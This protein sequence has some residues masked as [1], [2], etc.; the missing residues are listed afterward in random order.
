M[1]LMGWSGRR[2]AHGEVGL[3][4]EAVEFRGADRLWHGG[5][6][7]S[8]IRTGEEVIISSESDGT[9]SPFGGVVV[10]FQAAI[11]RVARQRFPASQRIL[12][13]TVVSDSATAWSSSLPATVERFQQGPRAGLP[14]LRRSSGDGRGSPFRSRTEPRS[15]PALP[16]PP[17]TCGQPGDRRISFARAPSKRPR[18]SPRRINL[19]DPRVP[20]GLQ[21][22]REVAQ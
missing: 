11:F 8:V 2:D 10:D 5:A 14:D 19:V 22:A 21:R 1:R 9:Q 20:V 17:A 16:A 4:I 12:Q 13:A 15:V 7:T 3:R 18:E 6:F